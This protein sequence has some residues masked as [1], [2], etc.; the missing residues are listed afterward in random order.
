MYLR[1]KEKEKGEVTIG[2]GIWHANP[3]YNL[4]MVK[5][6]YGAQYSFDGTTSVYFGKSTPL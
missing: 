6:L 2:N 5:V 1:L 4:M 3:T